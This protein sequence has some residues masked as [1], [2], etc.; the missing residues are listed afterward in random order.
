MDE[1]QA[2]LLEIEMAERSFCDIHNIDDEVRLKLDPRTEEARLKKMWDTARANQQANYPD[3]YVSTTAGA[4]ATKESKDL[5]KEVETAKAET[6]KV[7]S[8]L[9]AKIEELVAK[10]ATKA[11]TRAESAV[12]DIVKA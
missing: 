2:L 11:E 9:M 5:A 10:L 7:Q 3:L 6:A 4:T 8:D 12:D 1:Y